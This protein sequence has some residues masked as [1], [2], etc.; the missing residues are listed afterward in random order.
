MVD[1]ANG[2]E[3]GGEGT[4]TA[5][6][7]EELVAPIKPAQPALGSHIFA[8]DVALNLDGSCGDDVDD[9]GDCYK[10]NFE[11]ALSSYGENDNAGTFNVLKTAHNSARDTTDPDKVTVSTQYNDGADVTFTSNAQFSDYTDPSSEDGMQLRRLPPEID[12]F[13]AY[14]SNKFN[15]LEPSVNFAL[16]PAGQSVKDDEREEN[17]TRTTANLLY[18]KIKRQNSVENG[19]SL[20]P[21]VIKPFPS[22][23]YKG[24]VATLKVG[25]WHEAIDSPYIERNDG[26]C[27]IAKLP[28]VGSYGTIKIK[29]RTRIGTSGYTPFVFNNNIANGLSGNIALEPMDYHS[30]RTD[31]S[32]SN[33][34]FNWHF[35]TTDEFDKKYW[36]TRYRPN[37]NSAD[38]GT[39]VHYP[40]AL[41]FR[42]S[43]QTVTDGGSVPVTFF[44]YDG[45][46]PEMVITSSHLANAHT[47]LTSAESSDGHI[48]TGTVDQNG[49]F[50][51]SNN[52]RIRH[53]TIRPLLLELNYANTNPN[54]RVGLGVSY[55]L[56][57]TL[58][59]RL[60]D[61][62][63]FNKE[64]KQFVR[65]ANVM[66]WSFAP[67]G[68]SLGD[69]TYSNGLHSRISHLYLNRPSN[70]YRPY[71]Q[72]PAFASSKL[73]S[74]EQILTTYRSLYQRRA[75]VSDNL[76]IEAKY[77][78]RT[79]SGYS[80]D[81]KYAD[82]RTQYYRNH[83]GYLGS[84][85]NL[86]Y[87]IA[88][89][90]RADLCQ[91]HY[92]IIVYKG[93]LNYNINNGTES[94][95]SEGFGGTSE[96]FVEYFRFRTHDQSN[97]GREISNYDINKP[98]EFDSMLQFG[99]VGSNVPDGQKDQ[100][101]WTKRDYTN[102]S[103]GEG[104][105]DQGIATGYEVNYPNT[106]ANEIAISPDGDSFVI[107]FSENFIH[108]NKEE[109]GHIRVAVIQDAIEVPD[110]KVATFS[111]DSRSNGGTG[112]SI[113]PV[114]TET[115]S[116]VTHDEIGLGNYQ[117]RKLGSPLAYS[118]YL[119]I[120]GQ[121]GFID[122]QAEMDQHKLNLY[123]LDN[124]VS[125]ADAASSIAAYIGEPAR[126]A[127]G[128]NQGAPINSSGGDSY[129]CTRQANQPFPVSGGYI[130]LFT[131]S[132]WLALKILWARYGEGSLEAGGSWP[133][134][135]YSPSAK[136]TQNQGGRPPINHYYYEPWKI[137]IEYTTKGSITHLET[138]VGPRCS[139]DRVEFQTKPSTALANMPYQCGEC[140]NRI[141]PEEEYDGDLWD[142]LTEGFPDVDQEDDNRS[143]TTIKD[144]A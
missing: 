77:F 73:F 8:D 67:I 5:S 53:Y 93:I 135:Y 89:V 103:V 111:D 72:Y 18:N 3:T 31:L 114:H 129:K 11:R 65:E 131:T 96:G 94:Y 142:A 29:F 100:E 30:P 7:P 17:C 32:G 85:S 112:I 86:D 104:N 122:G 98:T 106:N 108:E 87:P 83:L 139:P 45:S 75:Y 116:I 50:T 44:M 48:D 136:E 109:L 15:A 134:W 69:I 81:G 144:N 119:P 70:T 82:G 35:G 12:F 92:E 66:G 60:A 6:A 39:S 123:A 138:N 76:P 33:P 130:N 140:L 80:Y 125:I 23:E 143:Y 137:E 21:A 4:T 78:N 1:F 55:N 36:T 88:D 71:N 99:G 25:A 56:N 43:M 58:G 68:S 13:K 49:N 38:V 84:Q 118:D 47:G 132:N 26:F 120:A 79:M 107:N 51:Y 91:R 46:S 90:M 126:V 2:G 113:N 9:Y 110:A 133:N 40:Q 24:T 105:N 41:R 61:P 19:A 121:G 52:Y 28:D 102:G 141:I 37:I 128:T 20:D 64:I 127:N 57:S 117:Q 124:N 95:S 63:H 54:H 62:H 22:A 42:E 59:K 34:E 115:L 10:Y 14:T 27:F 97:E 101:E 74:T 16:P